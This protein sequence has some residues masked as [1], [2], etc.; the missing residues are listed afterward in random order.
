MKRQLR[1]KPEGSKTFLLVLIAAI[2]V[3]L[4]LSGCLGIATA[5]S[6]AT[7]QGPSWVGIS[8][9]ARVN[10]YCSSLVGQRGGGRD[11][12]GCVNWAD[13]VVAC[14]TARSCAHEEKHLK[15]PGYNDPL[16]SGRMLGR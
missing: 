1:T 13:K 4:L 11:W 10:A 14:S 5:R 7:S 3:T 9:A 15:N 2:A 16:S 6:L 12:T 8:N